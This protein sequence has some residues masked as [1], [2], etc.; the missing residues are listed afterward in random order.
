M[1]I[2]GHVPLLDEDMY[3]NSCILL[4]VQAVFK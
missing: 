3:D 2:V 4:R 1:H